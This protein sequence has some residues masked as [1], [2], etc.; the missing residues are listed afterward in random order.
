MGCPIFDEN[1]LMMA[2]VNAL[3]E[4]LKQDIPALKARRICAE[5]IVDGMRDEFASDHIALHGHP[6]YESHVNTLMDLAYLHLSNCGIHC[7]L[8]R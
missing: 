5:D 2:D 7:Y 4:H 1:A 3:V 6:N 8:R